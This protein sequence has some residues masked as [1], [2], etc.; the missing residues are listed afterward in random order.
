MSDFLRPYLDLP[1][2]KQIAINGYLINH[3]LGSAIQC[4]LSGHSALEMVART[5]PD[6][7]V[8]LEILRNGELLEK[9]AAIFQELPGSVIPS[10]SGKAHEE[11]GPP[12]GVVLGDLNLRI[13]QK[14]YIPQEVKGAVVTTIPPDSPAFQTGLRE[15]NII[16]EVDRKSV[17]TPKMQSRF[18]RKTRITVFCCTSGVKVDAA[19]WW[20]RKSDKQ[21]FRI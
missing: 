17:K 16:L 1:K 11:D 13:R 7:K 20:S 4:I 6:T 12:G 5:A 10:A 15:G 21:N 14:L 9:T 8:R 3:S 2:N 18:L 19:T